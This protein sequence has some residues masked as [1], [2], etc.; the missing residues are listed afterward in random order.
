MLRDRDG[1]A[2]CVQDTF[3]IA[4]TRL[5]QLQQPDKLRPWLY[6]IARNEALRRIRERRRETPSDEL[7]DA[8]SNEPGPDALAART[9]LA[10]LIAEAAGGLSD[11]DRAVL[12]LVYRHGLDGPDLAEA[13]GVSPTNATK[14][15]YRLRETVERSLGALLVSRR[16]RNTGGG[17]PELAS[18][19]EG[20][21][22]HFSM[23]M[24]KR[25]ARHIESCPTCDQE[26]RR[27]VSPVALLG[28]APVF[29]PAPGWLRERTLGEV[30]LTPS[31]GPIPADPDPDPQAHLD[32]RG[33]RG[34][35]AALMIVLAAGTLIATLGLTIAVLHEQNA[36]VIPTDATE[37]APQ[38]VSN[39]PGSEPS[40]TQT[41]PLPAPPAAPPESSTP[42][43]AAPPAP[44]PPA[45]NPPAEETPI[46][47]APPPVTFAPD[48]P[49]SEPSAPRSPSV[50][51]PATTG[52][53]RPSSEPSDPTTPRTTRRPVPT[54]IAGI[55]TRGSDPPKRTP[56]RRAVGDTSR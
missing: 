23:L 15:A 17:C 32:A 40:P 28:G 3:C 37:M 44:A 10:D 26:R 52:R 12:E 33:R 39:T 29:I 55:P 7:P 31:T 20:W 6:A 24:R 18:I 11:R 36:D 27:M 53:A 51:D 22:G 9:E 38:P 42:S 8:V 34:R 25:I 50:P 45:P 13:L 49:V 2:D 54:G 19:L 56:T 21:D 47:T 46:V 1:A 48:P 4:A 43:A 35:R 14:M 5:P 30:Q 41:S 16:A